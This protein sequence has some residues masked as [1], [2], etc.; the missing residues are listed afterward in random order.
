MRGTLMRRI[1]AEVESGKLGTEEFEAEVV[2]DAAFSEQLSKDFGT[3]VAM[4]FLMTHPECGPEVVGAAAIMVAA[5]HIMAGL[6]MDPDNF[7]ELARNV[8]KTAL[9]DA[10]E[11]RRMWREMG[12]S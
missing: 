1:V 10:Q 5:I 8:A 7:A 11:I 3:K 9:A 12:R 2:R 4:P 6:D